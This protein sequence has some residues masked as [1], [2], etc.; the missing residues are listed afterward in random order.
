MKKGL[1]FKDGQFMVIQE[2]IDPSDFIHNGTDSAIEVV[3]VANSG[4][5]RSM[6]NISRIF[7]AVP[8]DDQRMILTIYRMLTKGVV[9][10]HKAA[11]DRQKAVDIFVEV[12]GEITEDE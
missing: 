9:E 10:A 1:Y 12:I 8:I 11:D 3:G 5:Y 7:D 4:G 2:D 6:V